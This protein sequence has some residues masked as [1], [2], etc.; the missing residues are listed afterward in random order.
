[1]INESEL[2]QCFEIIKK[3]ILDYFKKGQTSLRI[4]LPKSD[5]SS[6]VTAYDLQLSDMY[7]KFTD[8]KFLQ[9]G[10]F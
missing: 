5:K 4:W 9:R 2:D 7:E 10:Q 8:K 1:M 6:T 3:Y